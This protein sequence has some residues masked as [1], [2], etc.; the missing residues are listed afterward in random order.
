[1]VDRIRME[2]GAPMHHDE[3]LREAARARRAAAAQAGSTGG[4]ALVHRFGLMLIRAGCR[5]EAIGQRHAAGMPI[6]AVSSP[7]ASLR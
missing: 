3:L 2:L 4:N 5:L 6:P 1:M 7:C